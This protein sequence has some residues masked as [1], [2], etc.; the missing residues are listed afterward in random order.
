MLFDGRSPTSEGY[1]HLV[2]LAQWIES[3]LGERV[4]SHII[5]AD[6]DKPAALDWNGSIL[7][8]IKS[9]LHQIYGAGAESAYLIRPDGYIGFRSQPIQKEPMLH[10]LKELFQL[11]GDIKED[12]EIR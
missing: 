10:Y 11:T 6:S 4:R 7:L 1:T 3:L 5:I 8:D 9:E 2:D 12:R